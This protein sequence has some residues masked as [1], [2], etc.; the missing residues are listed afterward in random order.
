MLSLIVCSTASVLGLPFA[1]AMAVACQ[2]MA[3][4]QIRRLSPQLTQDEALSLGGMF[5]TTVAI[6]TVVILC[7]FHALN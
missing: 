1:W 3:A 5:T 7:L 4:K 6:Y 2:A